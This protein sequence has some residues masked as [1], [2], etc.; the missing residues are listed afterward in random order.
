[1]PKPSKAK[2]GRYRKRLLDILQELGVRIEHMEDSVLRS[3]GDPAPLEVDELGAD[4]SQQESQLGLLE[5]E[6]EILRE[7]YDAISRV[8]KG[9]YGVCESCS[10]EIP[11]R[12]LD[13]LP[14]ARHC[15]ACQRAIEQGGR[16]EES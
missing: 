1:M 9:V 11:P 4:N 13:V 5:N 14:Y 2:L 16:V 10:G 3:D 8:D 12:R 6:E 7:V 15:V